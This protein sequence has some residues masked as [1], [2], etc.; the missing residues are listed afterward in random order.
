MMKD[1]RRLYKPSFVFSGFQF[2]ILSLLVGIFQMIAGVVARS[3]THRLNASAFSDFRRNA[4][5]VIISRPYRS[6]MFPF[7]QRVRRT[8]CSSCST[9]LLRIARIFVLTAAVNTPNKSAIWL[10]VSHTPFVVGRIVTRPF[11]IVMGCIVIISFV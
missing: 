11:S 3:T 4:K 1:K 2:N 7:R 8:T 6:T 9:P 10:C 5:A